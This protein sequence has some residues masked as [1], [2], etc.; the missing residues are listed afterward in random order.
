LAV[1]HC[2]SHK[3]GRNGEDVFDA[4]VYLFTESGSYL[5][6]YERT[7]YYGHAEFLIPS[8]SYKFRVDYK[9]TQYWSDVVNVSAH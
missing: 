8:R 5:G 1:P 4:P 7:D 6:R 3:G 2:L 9:G